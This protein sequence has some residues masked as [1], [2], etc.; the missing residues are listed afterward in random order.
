MVLVG[1]KNLAPLLEQAPKHLA[2]EEGVAVGRG[3]EGLRQHRR[4]G[5]A[6]DFG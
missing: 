3:E 4:Q 6:V 1:T 2:D 5:S